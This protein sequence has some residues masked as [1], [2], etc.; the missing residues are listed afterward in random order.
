MDSQPSTMYFRLSR[1]VAFARSLKH[2]N[3]ELPTPQT[4]PERRKN[5]STSSC[6]LRTRHHKGPI[7]RVPGVGT[8]RRMAQRANDQA[9][10]FAGWPHLTHTCSCAMSWSVPSPMFRQRD[11]KR[12]NRTTDPGPLLPVMLCID[13]GLNPVPGS[14]REK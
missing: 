4:Q 7:L 2:F 9:S 11:G 14:L 8:T 3:A 10:P 13:V 12:E 1:R 5:E 6:P